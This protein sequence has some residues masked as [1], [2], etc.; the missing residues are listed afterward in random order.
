MKISIKQK[1]FLSFILI[2]VLYISIGLI[3]LHSIRL[4]KNNV[5]LTLDHPLTVT[6]ATINIELLVTTI[7]RA[8]KDIV[9]ADSESERNKYVDLINENEANAIKNFEIIQRQILGI[10]GHNMIDSIYENFVAWAPIRDQII[11]QIKLG[12]YEHAQE[13]SKNVGDEYVQQLINELKRVE[14]YAAGKAIGF[15][16][17]SS[18][19]SKKASLTVSV[20]LI[21]GGLISLFIAVYLSFNFSNRITALNK[22][23]TR[24]AN[25]EFDQPIELKGNDELRKLAENFN[26]MSKQLSS[27]YKSLEKKVLDRTTELEQKNKELLDL[28]KN[29]EGE[30]LARTAELEEKVQ[31]LNKSQKAMLYMVE[32]LNLITSE[33]KTERKRLKI[34]NSELDAFTY[35]VSHDLRAPLRAINGFSEFLLEDYA[36]KLDEEGNRYL[37]V[38]RQNASKMDGLISDMLNLS[39]ISRTE[40]RLSNVDMGQTAQSIFTEIATEKENKDFNLIIGNIP[41]VK[42]DLKLI[43]QVWQNLIGNALKYSVG[44]EVKKI[45]I[46]AEENRSEIIYCVKDWGAGFNPKYKHKLFGVFQRLHTEDE[47]EGTGVGLAIVQRIIH[48]HGGRVWAEGSPGKGAMFWFS[49]PKIG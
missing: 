4:L 24:M 31:K 30:V 44:S 23:T 1:L 9:I 33:L 34:S 35:S 10:E 29:L 7:Q 49:L 15:N 48:R 36:S 8:I 41:K 6:R 20:F 22:A 45:E 40:L 28:Q 26:L 19:I 2:N 37:T 43:N 3:S 13:I 16:R 25:G 18:E 39:R 46:R 14:N 21:F 32:D 38:I 47:F 17:N 11:N 5:Q 12:N 42:C 27:V